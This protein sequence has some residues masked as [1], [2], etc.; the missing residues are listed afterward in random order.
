METKGD[1]PNREDIEP[2]TELS[3]DAKARVELLDEVISSG[4]SGHAYLVSVDGPDE[5]FHDYN[6]HRFPEK[7]WVFKHGE[8]KDFWIPGTDLGTIERHYE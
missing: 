1:I 6:T 7:G 2:P 3:E 4:G 5:H 8:D